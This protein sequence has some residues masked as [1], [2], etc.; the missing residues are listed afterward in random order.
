MA[1]HRVSHDALRKLCHMV[2]A[3]S[4]CVIESMVISSRL[5]LLSVMMILS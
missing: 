3:E 2:K 1:V 4:T 5:S